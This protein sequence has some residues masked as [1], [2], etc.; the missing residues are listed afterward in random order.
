MLEKRKAVRQFLDW[1]NKNK[2]YCGFDEA[3]V[4]DWERQVIISIFYGGRCAR[5][6]KT[7]FIQ[8]LAAYDEY[9]D[10]HKLSLPEAD[11]ICTKCGL[12]GHLTI[13]CKH[14]GTD[15]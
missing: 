4:T 11:L 15:F 13:N 2:K 10:A 12:R 1:V 6:G 5:S 9:Q 7:R 8:L 3:G 14:I